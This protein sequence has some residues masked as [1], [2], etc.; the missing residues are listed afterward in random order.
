MNLKLIHVS[1][2]GPWS[3]TVSGAHVNNNF[4]SQFKFYENL[5]LL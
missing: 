2:V 5:I 3:E 1:K 4:P